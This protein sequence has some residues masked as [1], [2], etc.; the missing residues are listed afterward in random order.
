[1]EGKQQ[2]DLHMKTLSCK[3][4]LDVILSRLQISRGDG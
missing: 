1:M 2:E 4:E 3:I